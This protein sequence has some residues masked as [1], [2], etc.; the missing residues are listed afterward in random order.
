MVETVGSNQEKKTTEEV[1]K[2]EDNVVA[3]RTRKFFRVDVEGEEEHKKQ[4]QQQIDEAKQDP[5]KSKLIEYIRNNIIGDDEVFKSPYGY[6]K[7]TYC[8]YIASGRSLA[9]IEEYIRKEVLTMYANTH[10]TTS[11]TGHQSTLFRHEARQIILSAVNAA[12]TDKLAFCGSGATAAV[13]KLVHILGLHKSGTP[14]VVFVGPY[15]HHSNLLPWREAN[16]TV[17]NIEE[18]EFGRIST[19]DLEEKLK[20]YGALQPR[21][22]MIGA[23]SAASNVTGLLTD[24]N[25]ITALLHRHGALAVWDYACAAPYVKIDMNPVVD[26]PDRELMRK[27]AIFI[28]PHKFIGGVETPGI[29]IAKKHL[30]I[31]KV[32][33]NPGGGTVFYVTE[34]DHRYLRKSYEREEGGT[35]SIVGAIR[36]GMVFQL[37]AAVGDEVIEH[38]ERDFCQRAMAEF[39]K[40]KNIVVLGNTEIPR[41]AVFSFMIRHKQ[42]FLHYNYVAM[43]LNDLFGIQCRGGCVCAGPY[44]QHLLGLDYETSKKIEQVLLEDDDYEFLRPG[45]TRISFNYFIDE[46]T[47]QYI[48]DAVQFVADHGWKL[49]PH[50]TFYP[51]TNEWVHNN[52]KKFT[53][54][55]WLHNISYAND[56]ME[57]RN[58]IGM[59]V[60]NKEFK[61]YMEEAQKILADATEDFLKKSFTLPDQKFLLPEHAEKL[62]WFIYPSEAL[63]DLRG[64]NGYT[65]NN[66][67]APK[68]YVHTTESAPFHTEANPQPST[69]VTTTEAPKQQQEE[70]EENPFADMDCASEP[71]VILWPKMDKKIYANTKRA[72]FEFGMLK[73]NDRVLLGLSGGKD[74]LTMLHVLKALQRKLPFKF[75]LGAC[76]VDP[77]T[78]A[79]DPSPL[80]KYMNLLGIPYFFESDNLIETAKECNASSICSWCSRMKRG[81]LY[82]CARREGYNVLVLAQHMDD[83]AES[84]IMSIFHNGY[85]RTQKV[86]YMNDAG[87]VRVIRPFVYVREKDIKKWAWDSNLPIINENCPACFEIPKERARVK[88]LLASQEHL[89]PNLF[90]SLLSSMRPLMEKDMDK[91][92]GTVKKFKTRTSKIYKKQEDNAKKTEE[93]DD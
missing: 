76:T 80:K 15:E 75:T 39:K 4:H 61:K 88:A 84:F 91:M 64:G 8:D 49:L 54:R 14:A 12:K 58:M 25:T 92:V 60:T 77:Q 34:K 89:Y 55:R 83:L 93:D 22:M 13:N 32:P 26:G 67:M 6:R 46:T 52:N 47:F 79:Y 65:I 21:P 17:I 20:L 42:A 63:V 85:L 16:A 7:I 10:T 3:R 24:T 45:F 19:K 86:N 74:S 69:T 90:Y 66:P 48:I 23:F 28:S 72:I 82:N 50:Y 38:R 2:E 37:K 71:P 36:C 33:Q 29:L 1:T 30:F 62:R 70:V 18:D 44:G 27:D 41:L 53:T 56:K 9:F 31:N 51:E 57:Y 87:D 73:E 40:N 78:D 35:P 68:T 43:L 11:I 5:S 81:I 59:K